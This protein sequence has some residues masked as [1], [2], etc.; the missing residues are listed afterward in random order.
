M[1]GRILKKSNL[2]RAIGKK[3][4]SKNKSEH[5]RTFEAEGATVSVEEY[6]LAEDRWRERP[7]WDMDIGRHRS[8]SRGNCGRCFCS[9]WWGGGNGMF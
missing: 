7:E 3:G 5:S 4:N 9:W 1:Q 8:E 2:R 6:D